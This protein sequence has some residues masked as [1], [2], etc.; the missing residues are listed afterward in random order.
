M[1]SRIPEL[2]EKMKE[3]ANSN[4]VSFSDDPAEFAFGAGQIVFF[5][6]TKSAASNKTYALL[7]PFLQKTKASQLQDSISNT[8]AVY[9]HEI[10]V[11]KGRFEKLA[12]EV[13]CYETDINM[14]EYLRYFLA[15][16]FASCVIF[17]KNVDKNQE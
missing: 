11:S 17:E 2:L 16:C 7:E 9:K 13:L 6:L 14:K 4:K 5:L 10:D 12:S 3:V 1:A 8:I 15:G